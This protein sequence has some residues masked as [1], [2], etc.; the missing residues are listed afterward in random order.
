MEETLSLQ[1]C[2]ERLERRGFRCFVVPGLKEAA[3]VMRGLVREFNPA[4]A[5]Y[6]DS[7]TLKATGILD[8]LRAN[9]DIQFYDGF[10][11]DMDREEKWEIRR[12]G[13]TADLF[14]TCLLY[15]SPSP[16]DCS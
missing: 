10:L 15:T 14:L 4:S 1:K 5:S 3:G 11:P 12:R 2:A 8:D 16:R 13:M 9:P 6:G 7:M